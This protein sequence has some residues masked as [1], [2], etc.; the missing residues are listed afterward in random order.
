MKK[1]SY[2]GLDQVE[3]PVENRIGF[4]HFAVLYGDKEVVSFYTN[5]YLQG[6]FIFDNAKQNFVQII[7]TC[8]FNMNMNKSSARRRLRKI[9]LD[10]LNIDY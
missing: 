10:V 1:F 6:Y 5:R 8:D 3:L 7:G 4:L 9:A 2:V